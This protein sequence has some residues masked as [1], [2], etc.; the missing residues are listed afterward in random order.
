MVASI[1]CKVV[2]ES[3]SENIISQGPEY[4]ERV[5]GDYLGKAHSRWQNRRCKGPEAGAGP[6]CLRKDVE[7]HVARP[8]QMRLRVQVTRAEPCG[9]RKG[10]QLLLQVRWDGFL[11][12]T[13]YSNGY[14]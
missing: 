9:Q 1:F 14:L 8:E 2:W 13:L 12:T 10:L 11:R 7:A 5:S 4:M 3:Q 6:A